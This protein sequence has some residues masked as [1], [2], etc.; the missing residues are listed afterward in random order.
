MMITVVQFIVEGY[1]TIIWLLLRISVFMHSFPLGN[2][3]S[4]VV[5]L[6][7]ST[8]YCIRCKEVSCWCLL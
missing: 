6:W 2:I 7:T 5:W 1:P 8:S 4:W 3:C